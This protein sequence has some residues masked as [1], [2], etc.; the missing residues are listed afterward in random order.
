MIPKYGTKLSFGSKKLG[1]VAYVW[2]N[3]EDMSF[4]IYLY[5]YIYTHIHTYIHTY[6]Y[7][8]IYMNTARQSWTNSAHSWWWEGKVRFLQVLM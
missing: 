7:R 6:I 2:C 4:Y 1:N 5:I 8:P 3:Y